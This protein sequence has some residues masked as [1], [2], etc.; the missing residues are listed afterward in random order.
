[1]YSQLILISFAFL[2]VNIDNVFSRRNR[3][4]RPGEDEGSHSGG[5]QNKVRLNIPQRLLGYKF[6]GCLVDNRARMLDVKHVDR[7]MTLQKCAKL[8]SEYS[9]FGVQFSRQCFCGNSRGNKRV[10]R[11]RPRRECSFPCAGNK[12]QSCGGRW[13]NIVYSKQESCE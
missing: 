12:K 3:N 1:M 5:K 7:K 10:Y 13:R 4:R 2:V 9:F 8:C 11:R 6:I